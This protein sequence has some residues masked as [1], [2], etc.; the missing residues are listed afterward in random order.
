MD[1]AI[2][3]MLGHNPPLLVKNLSKGAS[4][5]HKRPVESECARFVVLEDLNNQFT[6]IKAFIRNRKINIAAEVKVGSELITHSC[7]DELHLFFYRVSKDKEDFDKEVPTSTGK[8]TIVYYTKLSCCRNW[9]ISSLRAVKIGILNDENAEDSQSFINIPIK[10]SDL[11]SSSGYHYNVCQQEEEAYYE[12]IFAQKRMYLPC[13]CCPVC[14]LP[15]SNI[16]NLK[17]H[18]SIVHVRHELNSVADLIEV[19][20]KKEDP[21]SDSIIKSIEAVDE[22]VDESSYS[23]KGVEFYET[24]SIDESGLDEGI[25][26]YIDF[27]SEISSGSKENSEDAKNTVSESDKILVVPELVFEDKESKATREKST[28]LSVKL[29]GKFT[30]IQYMSASTEKQLVELLVDS[31]E[32]KTKGL[33]VFF[34]QKKPLI[35]KKPEHNKFVST[36]RVYSCS[37]ADNLSVYLCENYL[38]TSK[39]NFSFMKSRKCSIVEYPLKKY[40]LLVEHEFDT[41]DYSG[42]V[43]KHLNLRLKDLFLSKEISNS[44]YHLMK[45]WNRF[46]VTNKSFD[47]IVINTVETHGLDNESLQLIQLLYTRGILNSEEIMSI[48]DKLQLE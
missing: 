25:R 2:Q 26:N 41:I 4:Y 9:E 40:G 12:V 13:F 20:N 48:L 23:F 8:D 36:H 22:D 11:R 30:K 24:E 5:I 28:G 10:I 6:G 16:S 19:T 38:A 32:K 44:A 3:M 15:F 45:T 29:R 42:M 34:L 46:S 17:K 1:W 39:F 37:S 21:F 35:K 7:F 33:Q 31:K 43:A 27:C 14:F 47:E 18:I